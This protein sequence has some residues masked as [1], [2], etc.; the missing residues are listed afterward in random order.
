MQIKLGS[1]GLRDVEFAVQ[2]LQ[3]VH[4]RNVNESLHVASRWTR[5]PRSGPVAMSG[6][7]DMANLDRLLIEFLR[8]L[9]TGCSATA[10]RTHAHVARLRRRRGAAL[11]GAGGRY[12]ARWQPRRAGG[13]AERSLNGTTCGCRGCTR[14]RSSTA[15]GIAGAGGLELS[16]RHDDDGRRAPAGRL[17]YEAPAHAPLTCP[18]SSTKAALVWSGAV[19]AVASAV[20]LAVHTPD[21]DGGL[22]AYR[23]ISEGDG[24]HRWYLSTLR[25]NRRWP[26]V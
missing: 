2:L 23:R 14:S 19:G 15:A 20:G 9:D 18:R 10:P 24:L 3:L 17:G 11:A 7:T 8:L 5:W 22:L 21:P 6:G 26:S 25:T 12:P 4:G 16:R 13:A 1:G